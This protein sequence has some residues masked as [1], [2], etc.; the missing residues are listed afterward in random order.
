[1]TEVERLEIEVATERALCHERFHIL[2]EKTLKYT[3]YFIVIFLVFVTIGS[4]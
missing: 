1:M 3:L 4:L 2:R